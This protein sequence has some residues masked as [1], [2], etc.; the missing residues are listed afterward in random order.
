MLYN[1]Y[2]YIEHGRALERVWLLVNARVQ[3]LVNPSGVVRLEQVTGF[4]TR[5]I[6]GLRPRTKIR[7]AS[8]YFTAPLPG[9]LH[10]YIWYTITT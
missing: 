7:T 10:V 9:T 4:H 6:G 1:Y 8:D 5:V 2:I 3:L